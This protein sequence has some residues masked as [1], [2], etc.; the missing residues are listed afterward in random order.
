MLY[1][2]APGYIFVDKNNLRLA[3]RFRE[4]FK[5][6][7]ESGEFDRFFEKHPQIIEMKRQANIEKRRLFKLTHYF[8]P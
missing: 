2:P 1:Y 5:N 7:I 4:G 6:I 8:L 3:K